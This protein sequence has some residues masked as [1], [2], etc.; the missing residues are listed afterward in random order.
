MNG[1]TLWQYKNI[2]DSFLSG[3]AQCDVEMHDEL[4]S[5]LG[6]LWEKGNECKMPISESLGMGLFALRAK[7]KKRQARLIY[8]F[9]ENKQIIFVHAFYKKTQKISQHNIEMS[10]RNRDLIEAGKEK[11]YGVNLAT[12]IEYLKKT[13]GR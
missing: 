12:Q 9:G 11:L 2:I 3:C 6:S 10:K 4:L 13:E 5:R 7:E 8:F 1:W